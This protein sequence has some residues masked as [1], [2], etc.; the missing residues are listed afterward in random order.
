MRWERT[1]DPHAG[2]TMAEMVIAAGLI[3]LTIALFLQTFVMA[4]TSADLS[5]ERL[6]AVHFS[7]M[8]METLLTNTYVSAALSLTNR[9]NW[10]T[11]YSVREGV[12]S[13][14]VC[15]YSVTTSAYS[16]AR[17]ILLTNTWCNKRSGRTN[18]VTVATAVTS[19]F[20]Y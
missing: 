16:T 12:T 10:T 1:R 5:D 14:Y 15:S 13:L 18:S 19:G 3:V 7:R 6:K 2:F 11:N 20:Q 4:Q 8:N 9:P 17:I